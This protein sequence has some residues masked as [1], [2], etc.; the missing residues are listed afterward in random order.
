MNTLADYLRP[1]TLTAIIA[2]ILDNLQDS[3]RCEQKEQLLS[4]A[5]LALDSLVGPGEAQRLI[6]DELRG[7]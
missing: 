4:E 2:D 1:S 7:L 3:P 6:Q 5:E